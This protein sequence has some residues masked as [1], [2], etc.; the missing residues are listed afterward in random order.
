MIP[1][2][3][4]DDPPRVVRARAHPARERA[5]WRVARVPRVVPAV[6]TCSNPPVVA[7]GT[8]RLRF[9]SHR[10]S[11]SNRAIERRSTTCMM[12]RSSG[13]RG[14]A[15]DRH[16]GRR[17]RVPEAPWLRAPRKPRERVQLSRDVIV[18]AALS[19]LDRDGAGFSMRQLAEELGVGAGAVYWHVANKEQ[20]LQLVFD[21]VIG[22]LPM[23]EPDPRA[24]ASRSSRRARDEREMMTPP[25]GHRAALV[26]ADPGRP[27]R[28]PLHGVAPSILRS[29]GLSDRVAALAGDI[30]YL[31]IGAFSF[32]ECVGLAVPGDDASARDF[33]GEL[34]EYFASLPADRFPNMSELAGALT[35]GGPDE[36]FEFGLDVLLDGLVARSQRE[37]GNAEFPRE[38]RSY[39]RCRHPGRTSS[40]SP[41]A[42]RSPAPISRGSA[43]A[44]ARAPR[45]RRRRAL[46]RRGRRAGR[47]QRR[48]ARPPAARGEAARLLACGSRTRRRARSSSSSSWV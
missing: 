41:S 39:R 28:R 24:G 40:P 9:E 12:F 22:E 44:S 3:A 7:A 5:R 4:S 45:E 16:I 43:S 48:R 33:I 29:G 20:L 26:R 46:R 18:D 34:R 31:Y 6:P 37:S 19:L 25:P 8:T 10:S 14:R 36:R 30:I 42:A 27:E 17:R 13:I 11:R 47:R 38:R 23:P 15:P 2:Q 1:T 35:S 32:E 21:R